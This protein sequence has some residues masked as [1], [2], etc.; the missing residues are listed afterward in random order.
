MI[1]CEKPGRRAAAPSWNWGLS[2]LLA[3]CLVPAHAMTRQGSGASG[4]A[5]K[6]FEVTS[7]K[8]RLG[9]PAPGGSNSGNRFHRPDITLRRLIYYA[10]DLPPFRV[11]GGPDWISSDRWEIDARAAVSVSPENMRVLVQ[12]LLVDRFRLAADLEQRDLSVF[13]VQFANGDGEL[14]PRLRQSGLDCTSAGRTGGEQAVD[15]N[16]F[17]LCA[18]MTVR[19]TPTYRSVT[20]RGTPL[21]LILRRLEVSVQQPLVDRTGLKGNFDVDELTYSPAQPSVTADLSDAP[22]LRT[23]FREQ[24]GLSLEAARAPLDVLVIKSV[25]RPTVN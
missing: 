2:A 3:V 9:P 24:L 11:V 17:P 23:A 20:I 7:V 19:Q 18:A 5:V 21:P 4:Q 16:G 12:R 25:E 13:L 6:Q 10:Y 22:S 1:Q 8:P 14:G 15:G